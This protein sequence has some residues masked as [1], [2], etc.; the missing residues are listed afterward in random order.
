MVLCIVCNKKHANF[1]YNTEPKGLYCFGC[2]LNDMINVLSKK[3]IN[4]NL[5]QPLYNYKGQTKPLYCFSCK[6]QGMINVISKKCINCETRPSYNYKDQQKGLYC[7]NC[8]LDG[9]IN[10]IDKKCIN[11]KNKIP[12]YNYIGQTKGL[13]C[14]N[15]KLDGMIN[16]KDK[17]CIICKMKQA[18][19]NYKTESKRLYCSNCKLD[20]MI[21][22]KS[23]KCI[24]C[25]DKKPNF[26]YKDQSKGLYC[27][28]CKLSDMVDVIHK[29]CKDCSTRPLPNYD[30]CSTCLRHHDP[31]NPRWTTIKQKEIFIGKEIM[32]EFP[33]INWKLDSQIDCQSC[34]KRRPDLYVDLF[35]HVLLIEIDEDQHKNYQCENKRIMEISQSFNHRPLTL[36][37]FNPDKYDN[38][39]GIFTFS[40]DGI[41]IPNENYNDRINT[42]FET[43]H[44]QL[45]S[46]PDKTIT[47]IKLFYN[48]LH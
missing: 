11:C 28:V 37:R 8:K 20:G 34:S 5:I 2:K 24:I 21:D 7:S 15:C 39:K 48:K 26:N 12:L 40:K 13:Y 18:C 19:F 41:T 42:L 45:N 23:K 1:N 22:I 17:K 43:I 25:K 4:C 47:E 16:I 35:T 29:T 6:K 32:R 31:Y 3:C 38:H 44:C 27:N 36:V 14:S 33:D 9:M 46:R 10:V 30:Y